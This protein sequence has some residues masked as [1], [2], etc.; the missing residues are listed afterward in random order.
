MASLSSA[1][2][3]SA[4]GLMVISA[5]ESLVVHAALS[6]EWMSEPTKSDAKR[7]STTHT[8]KQRRSPNGFAQRFMIIA[9]MWQSKSCPVAA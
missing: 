4:E 2:Q 9:A 8:I 3:E 1:D 5:F 7:N 6:V